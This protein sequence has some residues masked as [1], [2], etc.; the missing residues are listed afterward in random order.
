MAFGQNVSSNSDVADFRCE[1]QSTPLKSIAQSSSVANKQYHIATCDANL[2][3]CNTRS[4]L[5]RSMV[6]HRASSAQLTP[7]IRCQNFYAPCRDTPCGKVWY[8][9]PNRPRRYKPNYTR[10][11]ANFRISGVKQLLGA[12]CWIWHFTSS[13]FAE[14]SRC[15]LFLCFPRRTGLGAVLPTV[16]CFCIW[17]TLLLQLHGSFLANIYPLSSN[18]NWVIEWHLSMPRWTKA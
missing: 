9:S 5:C 15:G 11:L 14:S 6:K 1:S 10:F 2:M 17:S 12:E 16:I 18:H 3:S 4:I 13:T 7:K 8:N